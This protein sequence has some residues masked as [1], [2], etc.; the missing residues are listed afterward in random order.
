MTSVSDKKA[1]D[2]QRSLTDW[3]PGDIVLFSGRGPL[4]WAIRGW[5]CSP[6]SYIATVAPVTR[7]ALL[8]ASSDGI[9][10]IHRQIAVWTDCDWLFESAADVF[11]MRQL[12]R[13]QFFLEREAYQW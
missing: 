12:G 3:Q 1:E 5:T 13:D 11:L 10:V 2:W 4:S 6:Y 8:G 9:P 7:G